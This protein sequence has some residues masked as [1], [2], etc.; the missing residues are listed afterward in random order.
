MKIIIKINAF[1]KKQITDVNT[2]GIRE[3]FRKFYLLI[4]FLAVILMDIIAIVP[5]LIIRLISPWF[6]IRIERIPAGN[7]G[8]FVLMTSMYYCKKHLK[9]DQPKKKFIDLLYLHPDSKIYNKQ[10]EKM[11]KRKIKIY[12]SFFLDSIR[13]ANRF[14]P[15]WRNHI[16]TNLLV[17][18]RDKNNIFEKYKPLDFLRDEEIH[19]K[20]ILNKFGLNEKDKFVCFAIRDGAYQKKKISSTDRNWSYHD[21][22]H[23][24]INNFMLAAE[25]LTKRG[26]FVFR[27]GVVAEKKFTSKNPKI[28]DYVNSNLRSDF[29]DVY[30]GAH[31]SFCLSTGYGFEDVPIIFR[32]PIAHMIQPLGNA[33]T[34]NEKYL[35]LTKHH[36]NKKEKREMSLSEIFSSGAGFFF[37]TKDFEK[38]G[39]ELRDN[40]PEEI[41]DFV[42]EMLDNIES[43]NR[44][45]TEDDELQ[46]K[47]KI[48]YLTN[49]KKA[50]FHETI[51]DEFANGKREFH[52]EIKSRYSGKFLREN[53]MWLN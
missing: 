38:A 30:L 43:K 46:N 33:Y 5:C 34:H 10:I 8:D 23:T 53:K 15:G 44:Y 18:E 2:Y 3:L 29:M 45:T 40:T 22:R 20:K 14:I 12:P 49:I 19:G 32:K 11:W 27:M 4:K 16:I 6:I 1:I 13:R 47:F 51:K 35:I 9:I 7:F 36:I 24:D 50:N 31:C 41:K 21:F 37:H 52:N 48:L 28:I 26:Y 25:E 42:L 17:Q 39:I